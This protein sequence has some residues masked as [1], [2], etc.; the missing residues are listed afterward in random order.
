ME[1]FHACLRFFME[2][3]ENLYFEECTDRSLVW[4]FYVSIWTN[5]LNTEHTDLVETFVFSLNR[6]LFNELLCCTGFKQD[7]EC[8]RMAGW[9]VGFCFGPTY[10][11]IQ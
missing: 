1:R 8:H 9:L 7:M 4:L 5:A 2:P 6:S 11:V 3:I 10:H